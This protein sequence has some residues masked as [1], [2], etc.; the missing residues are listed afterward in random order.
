MENKIIMPPQIHNESGLENQ[1][2]LTVKEVAVILKTNVSYVHKLRKSGH[3]PFLK[4]GQYKIRREA[5]EKFLMLNE[6]KDLTDPFDVK[7]LI[8]NGKN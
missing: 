8:D 6:G 7:E 4:I 3:L 1:M 5:L 2:L